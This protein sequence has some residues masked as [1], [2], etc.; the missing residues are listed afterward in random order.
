MSRIAIVILLYHRHKV[1]YFILTELVVFS[2]ISVLLLT[3]C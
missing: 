2:D 1:T 3:Q